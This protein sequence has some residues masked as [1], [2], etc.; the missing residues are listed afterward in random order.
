MQEMEKN[1][2][3][4]K[5]LPILQYMSMSM[6]GAQG[7]GS[8]APS[9]DQHSSASSTGTPTNP[10]EAVMKGLGGLF[11]KKKKKDDAAAADGSANSAA[12]SSIPPPPPSVPGAL[13]EMTIEVGAFSD[14]TLDPALFAVPADYKRVVNDANHI[15]GK[16]AK[17]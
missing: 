6:V 11:G 9:Q 14:A 10:S 3:L 8:S 13:V 7:S 5:G 12:A 4:Y 15:L 2:S 16:P 17:Q 1:Q